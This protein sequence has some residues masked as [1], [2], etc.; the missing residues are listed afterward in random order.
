MVED[1][2]EAGASETTKLVSVKPWLNLSVEAAVALTTQVPIAVKD[3]TPVVGWT[4]QLVA[5]AD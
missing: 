2:E 4:V 5:P 1:E 3:R